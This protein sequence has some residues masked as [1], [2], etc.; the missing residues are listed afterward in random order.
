MCVCVR[1][2]FT[3]YLSANFCSASFVMSIGFYFC[4]QMFAPY[5]L[6]CVCV[7]QAF[8]LRQS[9]L[10]AENTTLAFNLPL[11]NPAQTHTVSVG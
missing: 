11:I 2:K 8:S 5:V 9:V 6:T 1:A 4:C 10:L 7:L 3:N